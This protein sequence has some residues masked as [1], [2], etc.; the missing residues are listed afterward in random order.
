MLDSFPVRFA[1][2]WP[3]ASCAGLR[4][5]PPSTRTSLGAPPTP[6]PG[7]RSKVANPG[8]KTAPRERD[9]LFDIVSCLKL[10]ARPHPEERACQRPA[11]HSSARARVS[12]GE[13]GHG[14]QPSCFETHRSARPLSKHL[15]LRRA[16]MLLSMRARHVLGERSQRSFGRTTPRG[17]SNLRLWET[18]VGSV[19]LFPACY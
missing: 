14:M 8:R 3:A 16:A 4:G 7:E 19:P 1:S 10:D 9:G 18:I 15:R 2:A 17:R 13:G 12:K 6:L 5:V 11:P